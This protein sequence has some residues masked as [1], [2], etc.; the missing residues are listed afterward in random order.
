MIVCLFDYLYFTSTKCIGIAA[1][2][3]WLTKMVKNECCELCRTDDNR[4]LYI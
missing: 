2:L 3:L 1:F 4:Q